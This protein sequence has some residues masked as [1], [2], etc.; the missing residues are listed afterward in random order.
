MKITRWKEKYDQIPED[1]KDP[2]LLKAKK[3]LKRKMPKRRETEQYW[4]EAQFQKLLAAQ[5]GKLYSRGPL[6]WR[7]WPTCSSLAGGRPHPQAGGQAVD[8]HARLEAGQRE[9]DRMLLTLWRAA[10]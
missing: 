5:P 2:G 7:S 9:L 3:D 6:P 4:N 10:T 1:T 8:G